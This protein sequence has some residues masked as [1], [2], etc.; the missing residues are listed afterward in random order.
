MP[1]YKRDDLLKDLKSNIVEVTFTKVT[2]EGRVMRCTLDPKYLPFHD[3]AHIEEQHQ[4]K[5]NL[6]VIVA[7]DVVAT[8]WRSFRIDSVSYAQVI[9]AEY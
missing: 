3:P 7:W 9:D 2:G 4:R 6:N 5:E 1:T 8:G